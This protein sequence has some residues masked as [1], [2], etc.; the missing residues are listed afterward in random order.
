M[1]IAP[2]FQSVKKALYAGSLTHVAQ[3]RLHFALA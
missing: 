1:K 3:S 2:L